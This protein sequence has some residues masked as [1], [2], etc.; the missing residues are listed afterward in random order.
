MK[1]Y[2]SLLLAVIYQ[3]VIVA[4]PASATLL[5]S[6]AED[7]RPPVIDTRLRI[8]A[9]LIGSKVIGNIWIRGSAKPGSSVTITV[10][11]TYYKLGTDQQKRKIY[12]GEGPLKGATIKKTIKA[13]GQGFWKLNTINFRNHGWSE[14]FKIVATSVEGK[15]STY[16][17]VINETKPSIAWD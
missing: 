15:N 17:T 13:D 7:E 6:R 10:S 8:T 11:S 14:S 3:C 5:L 1:K 2:K 12:K 16:V 4:T 9:P